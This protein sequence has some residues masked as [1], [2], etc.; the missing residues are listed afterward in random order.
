MSSSLVG[1]RST[2]FSSDVEMRGVSLTKLLRRFGSL[3]DSAK[4]P[5]AHLSA[6]HVMSKASLDYFITHSWKERRWRKFLA[7]AMAFHGVR[8]LLVS[9][10]VQLVCFGLVAIGVL[11]LYHH[12]VEGTDISISMWCMLGGSV[13]FWFT[14][15]FTEDFLSMT[16]VIPLYRGRKLSGKV[17]ACNL[18]AMIW[19]M[20]YVMIWESW[21]GEMISGVELDQLVLLSHNSLQ[22]IWTVF[23]LTAFLAMKP[24]EKDTLCRRDGLSKA[25]KYVGAVGILFRPVYEV[26]MFYFFVYRA[27]QD[28]ATLV[29]SVVS[30]ALSFALLLW[31][32]ALLR[33][34]GRTFS[35]LGDQIE[36]FSFAN[37]HCS[38]EADRKDIVEAALHLAEELQLVEQ[39]AR[40]EEACN[41]L[42]V[43]A[44]RVVPEFLRNSLSITGLSF[45]DVVLVV[46]PRLMG[47][48]DRA[49]V[50]FRLHVRDAPAVDFDLFL[51]LL[52]QGGIVAALFTNSLVVMTFILL[53]VRHRHRGVLTEI[54][55]LLLTTFI[56]IAPSVPLS[57]WVR[58]W[59]TPSWE[60]A[61]KVG[62][63]I[64]IQIVGLWVSYGRPCW[65]R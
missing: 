38:V 6:S 14:L 45:K 40:P 10:A 26:S 2:K 39:C 9:F 55:L 15:L 30:G 28:P 43:R 5:G 4:D 13:A 41:A 37:A 59:D 60:N 7:L 1:L 34:W 64:F 8:A 61:L 58:N 36:K 63:M 44:K 25:P 42:E 20:L 16:D 46:L 62:F 52:Q 21:V 23:E 35:E 32:F 31:L 3:L 12:Q 17:R 48:L 29:L 19:R 65:A 50:D 33:A 11:P 18:H 56:S 51:N 24:Y 57:I 27:S 22:R 54:A 49:C 53:L 47:L